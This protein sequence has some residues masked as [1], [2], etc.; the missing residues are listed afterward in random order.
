MKKGKYIFIIILFVYAIL[1][2][3]G[4]YAYLYIEGKN[5]NTFAGN[6]S[7]SNVS[8]IVNRVTPSSNNGTSKLVPLLDDALKNALKGNGGV[9]SCIDSNRNVS[10]EVYKITLENT[11]KTTL[12]LTGAITLV[13]SG[14]NN[15]Y[16]MVWKN[17]I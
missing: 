11:G 16:Q 7:T 14:A 10:C 8:L 17:L 4:T 5:T 1:I 9:G 6:M 2:T 12:K 13:A 3:S 15:I